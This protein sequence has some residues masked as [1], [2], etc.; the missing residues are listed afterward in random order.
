MKKYAVNVHYDAIIS[1]EVIA[2]NEEQAIELAIDKAS[3]ISLN[4]AV[5]VNTIACVTNKQ[6]LIGE[7]ELQYQ[8][9]RFNGDIERIIDTL[10]YDEVCF[11]S[12]YDTDNNETFYDCYQRDS[13]KYIG[14]VRVSD[15][16]DY[17]DKDLEDM[18]DDIGVWL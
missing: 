14:E 18:I 2:E 12:R 4:E 16:D 13:G 3:V 17:S 8:E 7:E 11:V 6:E 1:V 10:N 9:N 5:V 15:V